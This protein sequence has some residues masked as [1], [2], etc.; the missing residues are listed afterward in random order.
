MPP[1][2]Y[3]GYRQAGG[4]PRDPYRQQQLVRLAMI[5]A[6]QV[7]SMDR[8]PPVTLALVLGEAPAAGHR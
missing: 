4:A 5:L 6:Q 7:A 1:R 8:K 2:G 3:A